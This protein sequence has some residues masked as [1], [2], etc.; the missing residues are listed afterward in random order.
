MC[1][2]EREPAIASIRSAGVSVTFVCSLARLPR[3]LV[4]VELHLENQRNSQRLLAA[5]SVLAT[6][7]RCLVSVGLNPAQ[8]R[9]A[10]VV[11]G[12]SVLRRGVLVI[13]MVPRGQAG[14]VT[15]TRPCFLTVIQRRQQL[16][17]Y[18]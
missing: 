16:S 13:N 10:P 15:Y 7:E 9:Q 2:E 5:T 11:A 17:I 4:P 1:E 12:C 3:G 14:V 6:V 18:N 8:P